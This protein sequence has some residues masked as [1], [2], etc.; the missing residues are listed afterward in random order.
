MVSEGSRVSSEGLKMV[1]ETSPVICYVSE[2]T[3]GLLKVGKWV[4]NVSVQ[5][6]QIKF[7][8]GGLVYGRLVP[9]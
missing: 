9:N 8:N 6:S 5:G 1:S 2:S 3:G 4:Y 7:H